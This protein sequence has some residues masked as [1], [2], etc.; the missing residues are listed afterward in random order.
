[1]FEFNQIRCLILIF[2]IYKHRLCVQF[3]VILVICLSVR[4][5]EFNHLSY[6]K[7]HVNSKHNYAG[8]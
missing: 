3:Q 4:M 7:A 2:L 8:S 1:M 6:E 5:I